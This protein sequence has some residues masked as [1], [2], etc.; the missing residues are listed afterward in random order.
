L[1]AE[2]ISPKAATEAA[3]ERTLTDDPDLQASIAEVVS[4]F[5]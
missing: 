5:F 4:D 1:I 2:G 3:F